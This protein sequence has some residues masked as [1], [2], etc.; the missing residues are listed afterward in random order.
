[1]VIYITLT[2]GEVNR[3]VTTS[4]PSQREVWRDCIYKWRHV[5]NNYELNLEKIFG[6][7]I[8]LFAQNLWHA[9]MKNANIHYA[10]RRWGKSQ[11]YNKPRLFSVAIKVRAEQTCLFCRTVATKRSEAHLKEGFGVDCIYEWRH[12][13]LFKSNP[14]FGYFVKQK[15]PN[16]YRIRLKEAATYSPT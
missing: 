2:A 11:I 14:G 5:V 13:R 9:V 7:S 4:L 12:S 15:K 6:L 3:R 1:M 10:H 8:F 16:P